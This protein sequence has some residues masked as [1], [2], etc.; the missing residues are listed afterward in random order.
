MYESNVHELVVPDTNLPSLLAIFYDVRELLG[1]SF[2]FINSLY[3][4]NVNTLETGAAI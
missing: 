2:C 3:T 1:R 4:C